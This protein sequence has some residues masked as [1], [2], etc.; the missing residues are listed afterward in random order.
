MSDAY[1]WWL[2]AGVMIAAELATGTVYLLMLTLG[3]VAGALTGH[4]GVPATQQIAVAATIAAAAT[5]LWHWQRARHPRSAPANQNHDVLLDIGAT[6]QVDRWNDDGTARLPYRG[7]T[8]SARLAGGGVAR[9][10]PHRIA[11]VDGVC[12]IL[13]PTVKAPAPSS[14][15]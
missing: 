5:A 11:A 3:L 8:W 6:V 13:E 14:A 1:L 2:A 9:P 10:G 15:Q 7:S 12:L 4:L